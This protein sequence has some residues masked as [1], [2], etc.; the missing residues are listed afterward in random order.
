[1]LSKHLKSNKKGRIGKFIS[2]LPITLQVTIWYTTFLFILLAIL[3][4]ISFLVSDSLA[5]AISEDEL[6]DII[7]KM[8][9]GE[10]PFKTFDETVYIL[11]YSSEGQLL[12]GQSPK[13]FTAD[14]IFKEGQVQEFV[15][16]SQQFLYFDS[17]IEN[18][19][20]NEWIRGVIPITGLK[21]KLSLLPA[22]LLI[23]SPILLI[24]IALGGYSII[25]QAFKPVSQISKTAY[26]IG[27]TNDLTQRILLKDGD[28]EI[29]QMASAFNSMLDSLHDS[30]LREQQFTSDVSHELRTPISVILSE[31]QYGE[32]YIDSLDD[33]KK[34]F[35]IITRQ[36][37]RTS[38]LI[39]Q[40]LEISRMDRTSALEKEDFDL[41]TM[42][43]SI[44]QDYQTLADANSIKLI[45]DIE[46][47]ICIFGNK[48]M[49]HRVFDNLFSNALKFT[50]SLIHIQLTSD[51]NYCYLLIKDD[52]PGI[53]EINQPKI[54]TR[55]YQEDSSRSKNV[56]NGFGLG[57]SMVQK[58]LQLHEAS[59]S[60]DSVLDQ[61]STFTIQFN[62]P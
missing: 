27:R 48:M 59:I 7:T 13:M 58:I 19:V 2:N 50:S 15:N 34:S 55:F 43:V 24:I 18:S 54:W 35:E 28:D 36:A 53:S 51:E 25:K 29:H 8:A 62:K 56:N 4:I 61:G 21:S 38:K 60:L 26:D 30:S 41:S 47:A 37:R 3:I 32:A 11:R 39:N 31:S 23:I 1:M 46:D 16:G 10:T 22:A 12:E 9:N 33:A 40:L 49:I 52:G 42:L 14:A 20:N 17:I 45:Y 44:L 57:L 5:V 6:T